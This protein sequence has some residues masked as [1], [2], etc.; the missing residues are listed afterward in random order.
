MLCIHMHVAEWLQILCCCSNEEIIAVKAAYEHMFDRYLVAD[1]S[2]CASGSLL[3]L[4]KF[5][6]EVCWI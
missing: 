3:Q 5:I 4:M 6:L 2:N 1:I